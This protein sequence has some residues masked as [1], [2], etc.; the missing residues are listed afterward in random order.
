MTIAFLSNLR[1]SEK[2][3]FKLLYLHYLNQ[4]PENLIV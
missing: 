3:E 4:I 2:L 1:N